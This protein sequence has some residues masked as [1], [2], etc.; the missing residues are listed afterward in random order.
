ME[1]V[2]A[3]YRQGVP[4]IAMGNYRSIPRTEAKDRAALPTLRSAWLRAGYPAGF[5]TVRDIDAMLTAAN[6]L[7]AAARRGDIA[8][9]P[10][11]YLHYNSALDQYDNDANFSLC[12]E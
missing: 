11:I 8:P 6:E 4:T 12:P 1:I 7:F 5:P 3:G 10:R 2:F 9:L